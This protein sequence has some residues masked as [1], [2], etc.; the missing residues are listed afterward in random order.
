MQLNVG[1]V[2]RI[3]RVVVGLGLIALAVTG[4]IGVWG[5]DRSGSG[6]DRRGRFLPSLYP[7][8]H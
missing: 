6:R 8:G 4:T 2:D 5:L 3:A 7:A 1:N